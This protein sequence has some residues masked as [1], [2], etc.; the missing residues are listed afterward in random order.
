M[1]MWMIDPE[2][3]CRKHLLGEH[4]E[5]HKAAGF[6]RNG[7]NLFGLLRGFLDP[8]RME[9]R[10]QALTFEMQ[11]RGYL[12][13]S[14]L[15]MP[16]L[17]YRLLPKINEINISKSVRDLKARCVDCQRGL[18]GL[19]LKAPVD[20]LEPPIGHQRAHKPLPLSEVRKIK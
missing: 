13:N 7:R 14:P 4:Y 8:R 18:V 2:L 12:H 5:I 16:T 6:L 11:Q 9:V 10:H 19:E 15:D 1:R 17:D 3:L 20:R